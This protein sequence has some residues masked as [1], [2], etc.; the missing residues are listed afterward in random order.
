MPDTLPI[1]SRYG[2]RRKAVDQTLKRELIDLGLPAV[3]DIIE[4]QEDEIRQFERA[5]D[6]L[7][8]HIADTKR[9]IEDAR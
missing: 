2:A 5:M 8:A 9:L 6:K 4:G 3:V 7:A 1:A